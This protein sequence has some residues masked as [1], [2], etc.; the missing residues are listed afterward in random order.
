[1]TSDRNDTAKAV[2]ARRLRTQG[3]ACAGLGS[4]LYAHLMELAAQ[5]VELGGVVWDVLAGHEDDPGPSALA[6]RLF[7]AVHRMVL[8]GRV[9]ELAACYPSAGGRVDLEAAWPPFRAAVADHVDELRAGV[10]RPVQT[11]EVGRSGALVGGFLLVARTFG[12]PLRVLE[13]GASGGLNLRWDHFFYRAGAHRWGDPDSPVDLGDPYEVG[14]PPFDI[15]A[16]VAERRGCDPRPVDAT[17]DDGA[18]TLMS[19]AWPDMTR[20][21][22]DLRGAIEVAHRVPAVVDKADGPEW[23][24]AQLAARAD[25]IA[26]VVFHSVVLQY[27]T[28]TGRRRLVDVIERAGAQATPTAPLAWLRM[29][30]ANR[31]FDIRLTAWPGVPERLIATAGGHGRPVRWLAP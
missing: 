21:F 27:L 6:L 19:F 22:D 12:L 26:T 14:G 17:T 18:L 13:V 10:D 30:P 24:A 2:I 1:M 11:N 23:L 15:V 29:E 16:T 9:P 28:E 20:R 8:T 25:G 5:D 31:E 3:R 4:A 7:G